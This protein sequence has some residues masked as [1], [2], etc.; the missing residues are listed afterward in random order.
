MHVL[1][2]GGDGFIGRSLTA[3]LARHG[4]TLKIL[5]RGD[6]VGDLRAD[7]VIFTQGR[8]TTDP[9]ELESVHLDLTID[10]VDKVAPTRCIYLSTVDVYGDTSEPQSEDCF[11][12]PG[13][14]LAALKLRAEQAL[15]GRFEGT[16]RFLTLARLGTVYGLGQG[17]DGPVCG[18]AKPLLE[19]QS[20]PT[21]RLSDSMDLIHVE[22]VVSCL[23]RVLE[24]SQ[25]PSILNV[26]SGLETPVLNLARRIRDLLS[27]RLRDD[28]KGLV[29]SRLEGLVSSPHRQ[30]VSIA[31]A[32]ALGWTPKMRLDE[33][34]TEIVLDGCRTFPRDL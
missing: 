32:R 4:H 26:A 20:I 27:V 10:L 28:L 8:K 11:P 18:I 29:Q 2:V 5:S 33:G 12:S 14:P 30:R 31:R 17:G 24:L 34:L 19:G 6:A 22:D 16:G 25:P 15:T 9:K 3:A 13:H 7:A 1:V 23:L 21:E